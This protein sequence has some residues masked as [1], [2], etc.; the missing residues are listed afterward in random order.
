MR[1]DRRSSRDRV[2]LVRSA[3]SLALLASVLVATGARA[4][5][6]PGPREDAAFDVMNLMTRHGLH[7]IHE[8]SWNAYGQLTYISSWKLPFSAPYPNP[9][10]NTNSL[11]TEAERSFTA[12]ATLY[13]GVRLWHGA[14]AYL[15][16][17]V[18]AEKPLSGLHGLGG[19][20]QNFELQKTGSATPQI[21]R[22]RAYLRQTIGLG[23][24]HVVR[25]SDPSQLG[26]V[27]D[28][29]RLVITAGNFSVLDFFDKNTFSGDLRRTFFNM[30]F[31]TYAAYDFA[32]DARGYAWGGAAEL[33]WD[34]WALRIARLTPPQDPN[35]LPLDFR[36]DKH[37][38]DQAEIEHAHK[39]LGREGV[40]RVLGYRNRENMGRFDDAV[41]TYKS[42]PT[43]NAAACTSF[44]YG[45]GNATAP[46]L[47]WARK[48]N[49]K[50]GIGVNLEQHITEDIGVFLRGMISDG[51]TEVYSFTSTD[52]S[53]SFGAVAKGTMWRRPT[54]IA[55]VGLGM[56]WISRQHAE[57]LRLGGIDGFIGDGNI[58]AAMESVVELFYSFNVFSTIWLTGDYQRI[59]NPAFNA[60]R[61]PVDVLG[62]RIHAEF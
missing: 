22:S 12:S 13:L 11:V 39:I 16:P 52:Q 28:S 33:V 50:V 41:A 36:I 43:K 26:T 56:G 53:L 48:P 55:G 8:E 14:E 49:V 57:Y 46:D 20:I 29:R 40:V 15:V 51:R 45:S 23:G 6:E 9:S 7:E 37:Y 38:G 5:T 25:T 44:N 10:N 3:C 42:D 32:A 21:Y 4:Q 31:M 18:I 2:R 59:T 35:Q 34:D 19:A 30:A 54:D 24:K 17:E 62:A 61:G 1:C 27:V 58:N 47:C 60:D